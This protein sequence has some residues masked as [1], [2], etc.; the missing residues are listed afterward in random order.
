ML[1]AWGVW[2]M[3]GLR[4]LQLGASA[5]ARCST[6]GASEEWAVRGPRGFVV[7]GSVRCIFKDLD[8][9]FSFLRKSDANQRTGALR[10]QVSSRFKHLFA[11]FDGFSPVPAVA[12]LSLATFSVFKERS[13]KVLED[14]KALIDLGP[15]VVVAYLLDFA[16]A[17][18]AQ[19]DN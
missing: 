15:F 11:A 1:N 12:R 2:G 18:F 5:V 17:A 4:E 6:L 16:D 7:A 19:A 14:I 13:L 8:S 10:A 9:C 3:G